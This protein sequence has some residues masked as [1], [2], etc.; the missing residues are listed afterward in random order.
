MLNIIFN[1]KQRHTDAVTSKALTASAST[2]PRTP[3]KLK[4]RLPSQI[5]IL[6]QT[7]FIRSNFYKRTKKG[8][9]NGNQFRNELGKFL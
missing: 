1:L 5:T 3:H 6:F 9:I 4:I 7:T 8:E 2:C